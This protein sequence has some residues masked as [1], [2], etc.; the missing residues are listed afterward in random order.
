MHLFN[1]A[2]DAVHLAA[3]MDIPFFALFVW[4]PLFSDVSQEPSGPLRSQ[5]R[6]FHPIRVVTRTTRALPLYLTGG[7]RSTLLANLRLL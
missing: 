4:K 1:D 7:I 5:A 6:L 2:V 3:D